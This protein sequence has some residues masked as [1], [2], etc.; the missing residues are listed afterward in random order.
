MRSFKVMLAAAM[1]ILAGGNIAAVQAATLDQS[2]EGPLAVTENSQESTVRG[3]VGTEQLPEELR[4]A[5]YQKKPKAIHE[6]TGDVVLPETI[7][8]T[9]FC[10]RPAACETTVDGET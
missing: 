10:A 5:Y 1:I 4:G 2:E 8:M 6:E 3:E 7:P 9:D